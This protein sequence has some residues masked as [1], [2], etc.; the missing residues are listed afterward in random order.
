MKQSFIEA[1]KIRNTHALSGEVK[2]EC[3]LDGARPLAGIKH[4]Y[5]SR[6][7]ENPLTLCGVRVQGDVLL[8]RFEG[9]SSVEEATLLKGKTLWVAREEIDPRGDKIFFSDLIGLP[10]IE[11]TDGTVYGK[12]TQVTSRGAG[13]LLVIRSE[14]GKESYFP[15]VK[16]W[17]V[18]MDTD[19]GI[20]VR[21]PK[22]LF[23]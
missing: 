17:I 4:L 7:K 13:E 15:M 23:D 12:V 19:A 10:L 20:V 16:D 8:V 9:I 5:L 14:D 3:W 21:A 1:G 18:T 6:E 2:M 22:G 11:Q